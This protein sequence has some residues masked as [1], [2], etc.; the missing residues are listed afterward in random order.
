[1]RCEG[2]RICRDDILDKE[3]R[4]I[5]A[6]V[7]IWKILGRK[8]KGHWRKLG[9]FMVKYIEKLDGIMRKNESEEEINFRLIV[10]ARVVIRYAQLKC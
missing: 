4:N 10:I 2:T 7:G 8:N 5:T 6:E 1:L 3:F 9:M